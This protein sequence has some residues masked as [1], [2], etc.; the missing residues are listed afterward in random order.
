[1]MKQI[2]E[3]VHNWDWIIRGVVYTQCFQKDRTEDIQEVAAV[4]EN[5]YYL[6][7]FVSAQYLNNIVLRYRMSLILLTTIRLKFKVCKGY[8]CVNVFVYYYDLP[9]QIYCLKERKQMHQKMYLSRF[10][11]Y[12][13]DCIFGNEMLDDFHIVQLSQFFQCQIQKTL[14]LPD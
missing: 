4:F 9:A 7:K 1:M 11:Y 12:I 8:T 14:F 3:G 2:A 10:S 6:C 13:V 5:F